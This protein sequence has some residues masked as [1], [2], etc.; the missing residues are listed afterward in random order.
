ML[1][2]QVL[3]LLQ[4]LF[5]LGLF[6]SSVTLK[7]SIF[8]TSSSSRFLVSL[9]PWQGTNAERAVGRFDE[10]HSTL[11]YFPLSKRGLRGVILSE[12][13]AQIKP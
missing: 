10:M 11:F 7:S 8:I 9:T 4:E 13:R 5:F 3:L 1:A 2:E 12:N 6:P